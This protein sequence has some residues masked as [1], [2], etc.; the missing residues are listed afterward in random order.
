MIK[1]LKLSLILLI[2]FVYVFALAQ[3]YADRLGTVKAQPTPIVPADTNALAPVI[4]A[5][6]E[7]RL[8][9]EN[10]R[11][12]SAN[13][14]TQIQNLQLQLELLPKQAEAEDKAADSVLEEMQK[15]VGEK[16][17]PRINSAGLLE[18]ALKEVKGEVKKP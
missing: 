8:T 11:L 9:W 3:H 1:R 7:L 15:A 10:H 18:F 2:S 12:R 4:A 6:K 17:G 14:R 13:I 16:Y 5:P